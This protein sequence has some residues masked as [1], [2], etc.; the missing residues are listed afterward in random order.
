MAYERGRCF[1]CAKRITYDPTLVH[2]ANGHPVCAP[3][4]ERVNV[5]LTEAGHRPIIS[6]EGTYPA[7]DAGEASDNWGYLLPAMVIIGFVLLAIGWI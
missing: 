4:L 3:C 5:L 6:A 2:R 1:V 7:T